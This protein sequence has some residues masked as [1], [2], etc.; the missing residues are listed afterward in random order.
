MPQSV[1][2]VAGTASPGIGLRRFTL[3]AARASIRS[4]HRELVLRYAL[5]RFARDPARA[6]LGSG[7]VFNDLIYGWGNEGWSGQREYLIACVDAALGTGGPILECGSGLTTVVLGI[8]AQQRGLSVWALEHLPLWGK[9]VDGCLARQRIGSVR[10]H[11]APLRRYEG[12]DWYAPPL[13][14]MHEPFSLVACDGPPS[15]T[16]GGRYGLLPVM[17]D[18]LADGCVILVD[19]AARE[20]EQAIVNRWAAEASCEVW[21]Q[22]DE[23]P[24]F[25][26]RLP[27]R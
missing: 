20:D 13:R 25:E 8:V 24:Y 19:D 15:A 6:A 5:A 1:Q 21:L 22:G 9:R 18:K 10:L 12:F 14:E 16:L 11:V 4:A 23:K 7:A 2:A 27:A 3:H 26:V 17:K